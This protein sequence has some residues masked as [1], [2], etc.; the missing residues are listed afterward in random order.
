M[1][2]ESIVNE[3]WGIVPTTLY[4]FVGLL[5]FWLGMAVLDKLTPFS[6]RKEIEEDHNTA[7]AVLVGSGLIGLALILAA[8]IKSGDVCGG[9]NSSEA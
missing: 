4:F 5:L 9:N 3:L 6:I 7:L 8:A 1:M 2:P